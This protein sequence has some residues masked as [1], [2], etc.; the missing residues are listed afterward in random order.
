MR[1]ARFRAAY[2]KVQVANSALDQDFIRSHADTSYDTAC[3]EG[4][5]LRGGSTPDTAGEHDQ[6]GDDV[7]RSFPV[8]LGKRVG[9]EE[10]ESDG[11]DQPVENLGVS[12][13]IA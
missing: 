4:V 13:R 1:V 12:R 6:D 7:D 11:Q 10:R 9:D 8:D 2:H 5:V 3:Q